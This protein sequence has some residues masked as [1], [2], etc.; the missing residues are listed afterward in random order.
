MRHVS[1][2]K[3]IAVFWKLC[4]NLS[5]LE[6]M[7]IFRCIFLRQNINSIFNRKS[8]LANKNSPILD[9]Y[10]AESLALEKPRYS[11]C[12]FEKQLFKMQ[13]MKFGEIFKTWLCGSN[14][15]LAKRWASLSMKFNSNLYRPIELFFIFKLLK[16]LLWKFL[17]FQTFKNDS[18]FSLQILSKFASG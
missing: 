6:R 3:P 7:Q 4:A 17:F 5:Y 13:K 11:F 10:R 18:L 8:E 15:E 9:F 2:F 1:T 14:H 12:F 16:E